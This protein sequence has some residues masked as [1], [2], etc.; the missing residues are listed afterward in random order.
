MRN[1]S[2]IDFGRKLRIGKGKGI[3]GSGIGLDAENGK[4]LEEQLVGDDDD[5][6]V[7]KGEYMVDETDKEFQLEEEDGVT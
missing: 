3:Q 6:L 5:L 2:D 7:E 4:R 1:Q